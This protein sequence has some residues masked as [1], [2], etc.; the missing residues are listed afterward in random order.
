MLVENIRAPS[1]RPG[2]QRSP[3]R[4]VDLHAMTDD[5]NDT[6]TPEE[7]ARLTDFARACKAVVRAV[8]LY[9]GG[10]PAIGAT[11]ARI[12]HITSSANLRS[13]LTLMV[14]PDALMLDGRAAARP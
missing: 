12:V 8:V 14:V 11:L 13:P 4:S 6:L 10:H 7:M 5:L 2:P 9:P 3:N 1:S